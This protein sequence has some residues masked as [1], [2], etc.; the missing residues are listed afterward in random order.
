MENSYDDAYFVSLLFAYGA[1]LSGIPVMVSN[2][3]FL[4]LTQC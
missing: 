3:S 2:K 4:L 1:E